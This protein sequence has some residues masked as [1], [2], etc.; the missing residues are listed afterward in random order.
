MREGHPATRAWLAFVQ[1]RVSVGPP[2][3]SRAQIAAGQTSP[4]L[5]ERRFVV[6]AHGVICVSRPGPAK[7]PAVP[8]RCER[9]V[10]MTARVHGL[11]LFARL[12]P[13]RPLRAS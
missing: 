4:R 3:L 2:L 13:A 10:S 11:R 12:R 7:G 1:R 9:L 5:T 6:P 8:T